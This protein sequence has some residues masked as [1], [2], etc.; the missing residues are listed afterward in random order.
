LG[1]VAQVLA[2]A[3]AAV[4]LDPSWLKGHYYRCTLQQQQQQQQQQQ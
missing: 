1:A 2:D 3:E 4:Q